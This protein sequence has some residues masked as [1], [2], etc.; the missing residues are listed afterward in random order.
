MAMKSSLR[1]AGRNILSDKILPPR[2]RI[3]LALTLW[4]GLVVLPARA[5]DVTNSLEIQAIRVNDKSLPF[6]GRESVNL[7]AF[8]ENVVFGFWANTNVRKQPLRVRYTLEGYESVWHEA[9]SE[10]DFTVRFFNNSGDQ[11]SNKIYSVNGESSGWNG[12]LKSSPLR[13]RRETLVV[14]PGAARLLIVISSAGPPEAVGIYVVANLMVSKSSGKSGSEVVLQSPLDSDHGDP[15]AGWMHDGRT[16]SMARIVSFGQDPQTRGFAVVDEDPASHGE[17][18]NILESAPAVTPGDSLVV[19][20]NEMFSLGSGSFRLATYG[21]L[22]AGQYVFRVRGMDVMGKLTG[23]EASVAVFVPEPFWKTPWFWAT[24]VAGITAIM[25]GIS[26]YFV[27]HRMRREMVRLNHQRALEQERLRIAR[28]IHDDL[29]ARVT[30]ISLLSAMAQDNSS[31]PEKARVDFDKISKMSRELVAA[32]YETVWAVNPENDNL[33]ALGNYL[34]QTV[35]Q[36]CER[37]PLRCRFHV[38]DLPPE[39]QVSS[40]T[41]HNISMAVKE[42]VHNIVKHARATEV[43]M[44]ITFE[45]DFLNVSIQDDGMGFQPDGKASG[46]GLSNM[47]QRL[48][49]IGGD[50]FIESKAGQGTTVQMRLTIRPL[51][52]TS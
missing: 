46:N 42:A 27:W 47:K 29:G 36:L 33:E 7:G 34:C 21:G 12:L 43:T 18:H 16:P 3:W 1:Q 13:H 52:Q 20:W 2:G 26:R 49:S 45:K 5:E 40:Q 41:R 24:A 4:L 35:N 6:R 31:F 8:P 39:V 14:P 10:M 30:Q 11:I 19:E 51:G 50:C 9:S 44:R 17:W 48:A 37:T 23:E 22:P 25:I 15:P 32:L 28:D 38:L